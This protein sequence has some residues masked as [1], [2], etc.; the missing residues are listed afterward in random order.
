MKLC[1]SEYWTE[2]KIIRFEIDNPIRTRKTILIG[3]G[4]KPRITF[5]TVAETKRGGQEE[6]Y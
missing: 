3:I 4:K 5:S 6:T 2:H 1:A